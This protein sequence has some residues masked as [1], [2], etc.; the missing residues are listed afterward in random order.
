MALEDASQAV[1]PG[2]ALSPGAGPLQFALGQG[3]GQALD[4][5]APG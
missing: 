1:T 2:Q 4:E 3:P 5:E